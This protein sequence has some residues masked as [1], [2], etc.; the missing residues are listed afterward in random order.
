MG[1]CP[2]SSPS[3]DTVG[4]V[5]TGRAWPRGRVGV[6]TTATAQ[7]ARDMDFWSRGCNT[8]FCVAIQLRLDQLGPGSR[9]Y[10]CVA[11]GGGVRIATRHD[12][13]VVCARP[14]PCG[15]VQYTRVY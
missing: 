7:R 1:Y 4:C 9:H 12:Q 14:R 15:P 6:L 5:A 11:T 13:G 10:F 8:K 2:F 3:H